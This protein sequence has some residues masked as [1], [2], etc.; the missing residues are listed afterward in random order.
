MQID[1]CLKL[2]PEWE[3]KL[4]Y[5]VTQAGIMA[6]SAFGGLKDAKITD[7]LAGWAT[8][9][10]AGKPGEIRLRLKG[11]E[12]TDFRLALR[13]GMVSQRLLNFFIDS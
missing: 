5:H 7:Y 3:Y 6:A 2:L 4:G 13:C 11:Q 9:E 10:G 12:A 1:A 8:P